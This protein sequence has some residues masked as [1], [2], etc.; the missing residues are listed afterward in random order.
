[1]PNLEI[2]I[3]I[4]E[5]RW[6]SAID[7]I[8]ELTR[9][10]VNKAIHDC[11]KTAKEIEISVVLADDSFVQDLNKKHRGK[12]KPTNVLSFPLTEKNEFDTNIP[13]CSLGD[14]IIAFETIEREAKE[15]GKS[16]E[17]HYVHMLVHG[18]LHLL[19]FDH[20]NEE[21]AHIMESHEMNILKTLGIKNPYEII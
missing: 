18:C 12:D 11:I 17:H 14:V 16:L 15:Q 3:S 9:T 5:A 19:H 13:F 6:D 10:I 21:E 20:Q 8:E 2:D 1:M 4:L 7:N